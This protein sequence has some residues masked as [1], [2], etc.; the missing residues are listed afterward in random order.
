VSKSGSPALKAITSLPAAFSSAA[1][2]EIEMVGD[3]FTRS[4]VLDKND[5]GLPLTD[6]RYVKRRHLTRKSG[7]V[8][9]ADWGI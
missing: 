4:S 3:G 8:D 7:L 1:L 9:F 2:V 6:I 5:M